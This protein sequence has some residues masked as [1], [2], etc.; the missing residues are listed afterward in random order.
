M[1]KASKDE[2]L[3]TVVMWLTIIASVATGFAVGSPA[4]TLASICWFWSAVLI[5]EDLIK[6]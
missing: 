3:F 6:K 5:A 4:A 2:A 1:S